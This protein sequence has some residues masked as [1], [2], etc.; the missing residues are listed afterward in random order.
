MKQINDYSELRIDDIV[1]I[2]PNYL[3]DFIL[4]YHNQEL[5]PKENWSILARVEEITQIDYNNNQIYE[6]ILA[7][8]SSNFGLMLQYDIFIQNDSNSAYYTR[9]EDITVLTD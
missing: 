6:I 9:P 7:P 8:I 1:Y 5:T 4:N 2:K 3:S